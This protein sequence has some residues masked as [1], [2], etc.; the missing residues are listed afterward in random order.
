M[1][2]FWC[3]II[4]ALGRVQDRCSP[5]T[6]R[7]CLVLYEKVLVVICWSVPGADRRICTRPDAL[8][9]DEGIWNL[10]I[11][12][13]QSG[14]IYRCGKL[15]TEAVN[16][17]VTAAWF[18]LVD[19]IAQPCAKAYLL[20]WQAA[21]ADILPPLN[22]PPLTY[23]STHRYHVGSKSWD[24]DG[25]IGF[26]GKLENNPSEKDKGS[27]DYLIPTFRSPGSP[28]SGSPAHVQSIFRRQGDILFGLTN[29]SNR[30]VLLSSNKR[31]L[32][33]LW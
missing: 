11:C 26:D 31:F 27:H 1:W 8:D 14:V 7:G 17:V 3:A 2:A 33:S 4:L 6:H 9:T 30:H 32:K 25:L 10:Q 29:V 13:R 23:D 16:C 24:L 20:M 28:G 19:L 12:S 15:L 5:L 21:Y 22:L 18:L